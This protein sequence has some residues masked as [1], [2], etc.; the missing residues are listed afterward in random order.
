LQEGINNSVSIDSEDFPV[1]PEGEPS[2]FWPFATLGGFAPISADFWP[3]QHKD[4]STPPA[5]AGRPAIDPDGLITSAMNKNYL[6]WC[7]RVPRGNVSQDDGVGGHEWLYYQYTPSVPVSA[8]TGSL[9]Y[10][11]SVKASFGVMVLNITKAFA[12]LPKGAN[13]TL[14]IEVDQI[15]GAFHDDL[16]VPGPSGRSRVYVKPVVGLKNI[17]MVTALHDTGTLVMNKGNDANGKPLTQ[18]VP[19]GDDKDTG[20]V[21]QTTDTGFIIKIRSSDHKVTYEAL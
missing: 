3:T 19:W 15:G 7:Y 20:L 5:G 12:G 17:D 9:V 11:A 8:D 6:A 14:T 21:E 18:P 13:K 1:P 2:E 10:D 4:A 16:G